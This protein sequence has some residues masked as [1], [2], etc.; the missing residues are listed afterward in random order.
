[1]EYFDPL[2]RPFWVTIGYA[3]ACGGVV[4]LERQLR[5]KPAGVR[6]S[7]LIC[8]GTAIFVDLGVSASGAAGDPA[9]VLGQVVT[10]VGF[11]GAGVIISDA[12]TV[13]GV[14]TAAVIWLLAAVGAAIG[15]GYHLGALA[16]ALVAVGVLVGVEL[17][18]SAAR[19]LSSGPRRASGESATDE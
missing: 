18:E 17:I 1:M 10:G 6:T 13:V 8:L 12:G 7:M 2:S 9:R 3:L 16:L 14:T 19:R 15:L 4:G 5:G 11:I